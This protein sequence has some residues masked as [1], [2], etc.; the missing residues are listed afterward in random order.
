MAA[1]LTIILKPTA[2]IGPGFLPGLFLALY[3]PGYRLSVP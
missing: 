2:Y 3:N 1:S